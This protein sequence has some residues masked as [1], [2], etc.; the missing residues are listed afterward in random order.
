MSEQKA[1]ASAELSAVHRAPSAAFRLL[2]AHFGYLSRSDIKL[3]RRVYE[4]A[5][6]T[7][8]AEIRGNWPL[9]HL[10]QASVAIHFAEWKADATT[11]AVAMLRFGLHQGESRAT[12]AERFGEEVASL[13]RLLNEF[14]RMSVAIN[15]NGGAESIRPVLLMTA[16]EPRVMLFSLVEKLEALR[17][18]QGFAKG[19]QRRIAREVLDFYGPIANRVGL[20]QASHQL[21][22]IAFQRLYPWRQRVLS[23]ALAKEDA[24]N[25]GALEV[26]L[27]NVKKA[28]SATWFS[29]QII[30][31]DQG[32][33]RFYL[34]MRRR[35]VSVA[36]LNDPIHIRLLVEGDAGDCYAALSVLHQLNK[37]I[38]HLFEDHIAHPLRNGYRALKTTV[39]GPTGLEVMF[40]ICTESMA[41]VADFGI[42]GAGAGKKLAA[43]VYAELENLENEPSD[44]A[45]ANGSLLGVQPRELGVGEANQTD[46][47]EPLD[48]QK[49][50]ARAA[51]SSSVADQPFKVLVQRTADREEA[52][53][54]TRLP[55]W[56]RENRLTDTLVVSM[57]LST[58]ANAGELATL[59]M[60]TVPAP[61]AA[62]FLQAE[63]FRR[64]ASSMAVIGVYPSG[65]VRTVGKVEV[66]TVRGDLKL[67]IYS[68]WFL[69]DPDADT[70]NEPPDAPLSGTVAIFAV[71]LS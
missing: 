62:G 46:Q 40:E 64:D 43:L 69:L 33:Y 23:K 56:V 71:G 65:A 53:I 38:P 41:A 12:F 11:I 2:K 61:I 55:A 22:E 15:D 9:D 30:R 34:D 4:F 32:I 45:N 18:V 54:V 13:D 47:Y 35:R 37:H 49:L 14:E 21:Q 63:F 26:I 42:T 36:A 29:P 39:M 5:L 52:L 20:R 10:P 68:L 67:A 66:D 27:S 58:I 44:I 3:L 51:S 48:G 8:P 24:I 57:S 50:P 31:Q 28:F 59:V 6:S 25:S 60:E 19:D 70:S 7:L 1:E 16:R 17:T